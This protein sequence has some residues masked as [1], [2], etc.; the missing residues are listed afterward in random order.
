MHSAV[1]DYSELSGTRAIPYEQ[2]K[3]WKVTYVYASAGWSAELSLQAVPYEK[4]NIT[5]AASGL[6]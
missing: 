5:Y 4:K 1:P 2:F 6:P 3:E